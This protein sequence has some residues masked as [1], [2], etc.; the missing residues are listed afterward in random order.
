MRIACHQPNFCPWLPFF[1][2][3][4]MADVF[5]LLEEVQFEKNNYQNRFMY[6][7]KWITKPVKNGTDIIRKKDYVD[8]EPTYT[9]P[10]DD[11]SFLIEHSLPRINELW[12]KTIKETL[13]IKTRVTTDYM[14]HGKYETPTHRLIEIIKS[15]GGNVY[16]TNPDAKDKYLDETLMR[17][18]GI[19]IEYCKVPRN[20]QIHTFEAFEKWGIEGTKNQLPKVK[21][22]S[23]LS[24]IR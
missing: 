15:E 5:V 21:E 11:T 2:K 18:N 10:G 7:G 9:R 6:K 1:Y 13:D 17:A 23:A 20:L 3:M 24:H 19:D 22:Y 4:A 16:I 14:I 8:S 12:I